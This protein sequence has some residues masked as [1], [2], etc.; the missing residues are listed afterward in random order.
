MAERRKLL[1]AAAQGE[2]KGIDDEVGGI[3]PVLAHRQVVQA[4][5][6][7]QLAPALWAMP[8]SSMVRATTAAP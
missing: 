6:H 4:P 1:V 5:G 7:V 2:G 3:E 8:C